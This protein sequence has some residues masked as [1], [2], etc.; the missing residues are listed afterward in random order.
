M[1]NKDF[2]KELQ[3]QSNIINEFHSLSLSGKEIIATLVLDQLEKEG[4]SAPVFVASYIGNR[5][6]IQKEE[7]MF[8]NV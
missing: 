3:I 6:A 1:L 5:K 8:I 7:E 4:V 2:Y